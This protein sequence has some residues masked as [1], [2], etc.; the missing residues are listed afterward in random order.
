[1]DNKPSE[2]DI[3]WFWSMVGIK[4]PDECWEWLA[5]KDR[6]GRYCYQSKTILSHRFSY[7]LKDPNF[8]Q[9]LYVCH[10]CDNN[11]CMNPKHLF[12]G[13]AQDNSSD[14]V[15]KDRQAKGEGNGAHILTEQ[16][17]LEIVKKYKTGNHTQRGLAR[18]YKV[19]HVTIGKIVRLETW[20]GFFR[21]VGMIPAN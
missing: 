17:V 11:Y 13:T 6:Y 7:M 3:K 16:E 14:M 9:S 2:L 19:S 12:L 1:M 20:K 5:A 8:D 15:S 10:T 18:H 21:E 4:G